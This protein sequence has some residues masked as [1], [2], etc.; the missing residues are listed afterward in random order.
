M[1]LFRESLGMKISALILTILLTGVLSGCS[2]IPLSTML[3]MRG[4]DKS[5]FIQI[6]AE[7]IRIRVTLDKQ[8]EL[9]LDDSNLSVKLVSEAQTEMFRF[10]I[11]LTSKEVVSKRSGWWSKEVSQAVSVFRLSKRGLKDFHKLQDRLQRASH[12]AL[13]LDAHVALDPKHEHQTGTM[14]LELKL[15]EEEDFFVLID[16]YEYEIG[17]KQSF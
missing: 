12:G 17:E 4:F 1:S 14:S 8:V 10:P 16:Q 6:S 11:E 7:E 9:N 5:D 15:F 2:S 3:K 13:G